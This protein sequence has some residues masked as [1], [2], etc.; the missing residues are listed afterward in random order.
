MSTIHTIKREEVLDTPILLFD[1]TLSDGSVERWSTHRVTV[2]G[3]VYDA[4][5]IGHSGFDL[6]LAGEESIDT[7]TRFSLLLSNVDGRISQLDRSVGWKGTK[8]AV[9]FG[10]FDVISGALK[11]ELTS[12]FLGVANP[13]EELT[14]STARLSFSNRLSLQRVSVPNL[15]IQSLCPWRFPATEDERVEALDGGERGSYSQFY[16]CGYCPDVSGGRGN[17]DNGAPYSSCGKTRSECTVRGMFSADSSG[18]VTRRFGG[19]AFL[20]A[21]IQV[22]PFGE[23]SYQTAEPV[24][25]RA[26]SNDAVA[27][28]YGTAWIQAPVIFARSDGNLTHCEVLV[29]AG[30]IDGVLKVVANSVELPL[31]Q[32]GTDMTATGWYNVLSLGSREG[33]FNPSFT[34]AAGAPAGDPHGS[35][36]CLE[37]VLPNRLFSSGSLPKVEVLLNGLKVPRFDGDGNHIDTVFSTN[38]A[39]VVLDLL[40]RNGWDADEFD[41]ASFS[42]AAQHC[43]EFVPAVTP[44]GSTLNVPRFQVNL[45][46][47]Q[48]R[49]L[50]EILRGLRLSAALLLTVDELGRLRLM[51]EATLALQSP[52]KPAGS[53]STAPISSGWPASE[54]GDGLNGFSGILRK[55]DGRSSFRIWR[56][57]TAESPNRL[58]AEFQDAFNQYQQDSLSVV[59]FDDAAAQG[60]EISASSG[61]QG[62]PHYD[63]AARILRLQVQKNIEGNQYIDFETTVQAIGLRPGDLIAISHAREG[64]DRALFRI[65]RLTPALNYGRVK[66]TAQRHQD[67]WYLLAG[68][69]VI[70]GQDRWWQQYGGVGTPRPLCGKVLNDDGSQDFEVVQGSGSSDD[71]AAQVELTASFTPPKRPT[72]S[73]PSAPALSLTPSIHSTGGTIAGGTISY[74]AVSAL[75]SAGDESPLSFSVRAVLPAGVDSYSVEL[76]GLRFSKGSTAARIYRGPM[77]N[78]LLM[79]AEVPTTNTTFTDTGLDRQATPPPDPNY[80]H[81]R[82]QWRFELQTEV[83][84]TGFGAQ[85]IENSSLGMLANEFAGDV[86]RITRGRGA[87]QERFIASHTATEFQL[88]APWSVEPDATSFFTVAEAGWK[89]IGITRA[90]SISFL[91]PNQAFQYVQILGVA[92]N[93]VGVESAQED[94]IVTRFEVSGAG[95]D[96]DVPGM[97]VFGLSDTGDGEFEIGGIAFSDLA[98]TQTI[99]AGTLT[100]HYW[101][102]LNNPA[103]FALASGL[104]DTGTDLVYSSPN[105]AAVADLIQ[106]GSELVRVLVVS[107]DGRTLQIERAV[108][109]TFAAAYAAGTASYPLQRHTELMPFARGFFGSP[110]SG[111]YS[112]R[113]SL[114]NVRIAAAE[115][116]VTNSRGDSPTAAESYTSLLPGGIRTLSGGQYSIQYEGE[117]AVMQG[118]APAVVVDSACAVR[119]ITATLGSAPLGAPVQIVVKVNG[120]SYASLSVAAGHRT[121]TVFDGVGKAAL[122]EAG[123]ITADITSVGTADGTY[124]GRDLTLTIRL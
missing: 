81:A 29:A 58:T 54:F 99:Q 39:W 45:A 30:P 69:D 2:D 44:D 1:C 49:S 3:N 97:P 123:Q 28:V 5:L 47:T 113:I 108:H 85:S 40:R 92:V 103:G 13:I 104:S 57:S 46:L 55:D 65:L 118:L 78:K 15:R 89:A 83:Q 120:T 96:A 64:L 8:L 6:R 98:N 107:S 48:R 22:R 84:A 59:D 86:V 114:P 56:R 23:K 111:S 106:I 31:G 80:D 122:P 35:M 32:S 27:L 87:G 75:N 93:S 110:A 21:S 17:L 63:Q 88:T 112:H 119:D 62:L 51:N 115:F 60:C 33:G 121:S 4:R 109:G 117:L 12:V 19:F 9:S 94:A 14:D 105:L 76:T 72:I 90:D 50:N 95:S 101:N 20:P 67:D 53:N 37:V 71:T 41:L 25:G 77:P 124:P 73:G 82:F 24:D 102:E 36:A 7:G 70:D 52:D 10:F 42:Q 66:I 43:D 18:Q 11:S 116:C 61:A 74:Y 100:V 26:R 16:R 38:P 34:D 79:I 68:G 91:V